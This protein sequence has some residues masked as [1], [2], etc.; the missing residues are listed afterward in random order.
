[1][2]EENK[3]KVSELEIELEKIKEEKRIK[4]SHSILFDVKLLK[5][6]DIK[7][8]PIR[9]LS[10]S[11]EFITEYRSFNEAS[12]FT[13]IKV[14]NLWACFKRKTFKAGGFRWAKVV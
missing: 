14:K 1:M 13:G 12:Y 5:N 7:L 6:K 8:T 2:L 4:D 9:Q 3:I 10:L 11:G